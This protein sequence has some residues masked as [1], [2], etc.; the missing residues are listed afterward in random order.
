MPAVL[1][2]VCVLTP[3]TVTRDENEILATK[4]ETNLGKVTKEKMN[5]IALS[6]AVKWFIHSLWI[7][8]LYSLEKYFVKTAFN[9][10]KFSCFYTEILR[11]N[12]AC[13]VHCEQMK[14]LLYSHWN[15]FRQ[16][17]SLVICL[18]NV[19]LSRNFWQKSVRMSKFP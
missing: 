3:L 10:W 11:R 15:F 8:H 6:F 5:L 13:I 12:R 16:I 1:C 18:V 4:N 17:T 19:L 2:V 7:K 9:K 14:N